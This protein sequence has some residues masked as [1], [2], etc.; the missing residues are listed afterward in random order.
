MHVKRAYMG[1]L[2]R[3]RKYFL[4]G[5][6]GKFSNSQQKPLSELTLPAGLTSVPEAI[7]VK[8]GIH[9]GE[10]RAFIM[11]V[12]ASSIANRNVLGTA[13][14]HSIAS[15]ESVLIVYLFIGIAVAELY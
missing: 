14:F 15:Y 11:T 10:K 8:L 12:F 4:L 13:L 3:R 5:F 9:R 7:E 6:N 2:C 1:L